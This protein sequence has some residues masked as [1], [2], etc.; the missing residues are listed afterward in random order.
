MENKIQITKTKH[1]TVLGSQGEFQ[2]VTIQQKNFH[3][4]PSRNVKPYAFLR[5]N[6]NI[7]ENYFYWKMLNGSTF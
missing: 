4:K 2:K 5:T 1:N 3:I 6:E 7:S